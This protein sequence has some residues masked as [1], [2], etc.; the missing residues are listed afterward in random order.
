MCLS[1]PGK[2][3]AI[4]GNK[5]EVLIGEARVLAAID[6]IED[7]AVGDYVLVHAGVAIQKLTE[8]DALETLRLVSEI[9]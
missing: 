1:I 5:A 3:S 7:P 6:L 4:N 9:L 2:I 8:N